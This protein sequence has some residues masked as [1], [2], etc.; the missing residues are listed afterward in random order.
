[1]RIRLLIIALTIL[2]CKQEKPPFDSKKIEGRWIITEALRK[3]RATQTLDGAILSISHEQ[4]T[5]NFYGTDTTMQITWG[6]DYML[7]DTT[8]F[9][10]EGYL[11]SLLILSF[12]VKQYPF[13]LTLKKLN[14]NQTEDY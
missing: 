3:N 4:L 2:S 13:R 12:N 6:S 5:H 11:D 8:H 9:K 14:E 10:I 7:V 1:M